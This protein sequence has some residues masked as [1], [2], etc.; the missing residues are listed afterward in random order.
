MDI[1]EALHNT[2]PSLSERPLREDIARVGKF[3][4]IPAGTVLMDVGKYIKTVP[5]VVSGAIKI[6]RE[7]EEGNEIF[8]YYIDSNQTCAMSLTCCLTFSQSQVRAIVEDDAEIIFVPVEA[9]DEWMLKFPTWKNFVM[10]T[11]AYRFEELLHT[12]DLIAFHNM[13][14]R[15]LAYLNDKSD[16]LKSNELDITHQQIAYDLNSS[17]EAVSRLLKKLEIQGRLK[18]SRNRITLLDL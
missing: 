14:E 18:L 4:K 17:R 11:Y 5:L 2:F 16:N 1:H 6:M 3:E 12:I 7:D 15:L 13:D 10:Q 8:L 9:M